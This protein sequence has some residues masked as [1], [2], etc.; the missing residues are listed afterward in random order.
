M[1]SRID[2]FI[3]N[4]SLMLSGPQNYSS[5]KLSICMALGEKDLWGAVTGS[6]KLDAFPDEND[7]NAIKHNKK[8]SRALIHIMLNVKKNIIPIVQLKKFG[9][10]LLQDL[11]I[12]TR[13]EWQN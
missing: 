5:W 4:K 1:T 7:G 2:E 3:L 13:V 9:K 12:S 6:E 11:M 10:S 8:Q